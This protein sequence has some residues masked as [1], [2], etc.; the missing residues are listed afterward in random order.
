M[1]CSDVNH[2]RNIEQIGNCPSCNFVKQGLTPSERE[3]YERAMDPEL[4]EQPIEVNKKL[5]QTSDSIDQTMKAQRRYALLQAATTLLSQAEA[6]D[7][8]DIDICVDAAYRL[9]AEIERR[10]Q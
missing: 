5:T 7:D 8:D 1:K 9:L 6:V 3:L 4:I 10:E 2:A